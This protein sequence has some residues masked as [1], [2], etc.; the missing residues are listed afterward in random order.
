MAQHSLQAPFGGQ[1]GG[2]QV[3]PRTAG[4][5]HGEG[6]CL[7]PHTGRP[8]QAHRGGRAVRAGSIERTRVVH[9]S[10]GYIPQK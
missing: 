3:A 1:P 5:H 4:R 10:P 7:L 6:P 8:M 2:G 9:V